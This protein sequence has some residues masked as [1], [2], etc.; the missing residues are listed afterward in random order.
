MQLL[1]WGN[2][3]QKIYLLSVC[4]SEHHGD[5]VEQKAL[6]HCSQPCDYCSVFPGWSSRE[7][8]S[9]CSWGVERWGSVMLCH[10]GAALAGQLRKIISGRDKTVRWA[11][12]LKKGVWW[13]VSEHRMPL[14]QE[15]QRHLHGCG[16]RARGS[17][18]CTSAG[19]TGSHRSRRHAERTW[20]WR[21]SLPWTDLVPSLQPQSYGH[22][23]FPIVCACLKGPSHCVFHGSHF[24]VGGHALRMRRYRAGSAAGFC[25]GLG[26]WKYLARGVF[27]LLMWGYNW[28]ACWALLALSWLC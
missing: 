8:S 26:F 20:L 24:R 21:D 25:R 5:V 3:R 23:A 1:A 18:G 19:C 7:I 6:P 4:G 22:M 10:P 13:C 2:E 16:R 17:P 27:V 28:S 14:C 11:M 9:P 15:R 12:P